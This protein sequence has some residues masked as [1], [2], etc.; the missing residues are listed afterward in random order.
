M[1]VRYVISEPD[2]PGFWQRRKA[3]ICLSLGLAGG[4]WL[5]HATAGVPAQPPASTSSPSATSTA[6]PT[7]TT[8]R[9]AR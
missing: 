9:S 8:T 6:T 2:A 7:A 5:H 4:L 1:G 3:V